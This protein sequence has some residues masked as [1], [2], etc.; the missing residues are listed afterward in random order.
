MKN[1]IKVFLIFSTANALLNEPENS[2]SF[3]ANEAHEVTV[4]KKCENNDGIFD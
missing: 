3:D 2:W 1:F 4:R